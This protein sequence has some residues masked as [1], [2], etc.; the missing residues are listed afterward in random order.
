M[1]SD[2]MH[3]VL[4]NIAYASSLVDWLWE[5]TD[6]DT[7]MSAIITQVNNCLVAADRKL[8]DVVLAAIDEAHDVGYDQAHAKVKAVNGVDDLTISN[9]PISE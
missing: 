9:I 1:L 7:P 4:R 8:R 2:D 5:H 6:K 3:C